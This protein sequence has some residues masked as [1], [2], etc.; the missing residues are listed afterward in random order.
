MPNTFITNLAA[1]LASD[2]LGEKI[3]LAPSHRVGRQWLDQAAIRMGG[4]ANVGIMT[5]RR[6][7]RDYAE[8]GLRKDNLRIPTA[9]EKTRLIGG[10]LERIAS[11]SGE[12]A[13][14][15]RLPATLGL[16]ESLAAAVDELESASV[17][18]AA[19]L[20][21]SASTREKGAEL[22]KLYRYWKGAG[23]RDGWAGLE[24]VHLAAMAALDEPRAY[25]LLLLPASLGEDFTAM[26]WGFIAKWPEERR[27]RLA[28]DGGDMQ[29]DVSFFTADCAINEARET[30]RRTMEQTIPLDQ[31]EIVCIDPESYIPA[32]CRAGLEAFGG[33]PE[34]L[35]ITF[36]AGL[37]G[38]YTRPVRLLTAWLEWIESGLPP[39][40]LARMI[41][42]GLLAEGWREAAPNISPTF[43]ASRLR[44]L[45]INGDPDDYRRLPGTR[46]NESEANRAEAWLAARVLDIL[47]L[48]NGGQAL[49]LDDAPAVLA[50]AEKLLA[51]ASRHDAKLDAYARNSAIEAIRAWLPHCAWPAFDAPAWLAQLAAGTRVMGLG[52][53]PGRIHVSDVHSGGHSGRPLT[54]IVGLDD[55]RFPGQLRQDPVLLDRERA[56]VSPHLPQSGQRRARREN[57]LKRL[58]ARLRGRVVVSHARHG[59]AGGREL[60]PAAAFGALAERYP[61]AMS[62]APAALAPD[63]ERKC[64]DKRDDWLHILLEQRPGGVDCGAL[65]QWFPHFAQGEIALAAR[66]SAE[67]TPYDGN[68]PEA[69]GEWDP[70]AGKVFSPTDLELLASCPQEFFFKKVLGIRPPDR[71]DPRPGSWL[72]G[73]QRGTLLHDLFQNFLDALDERSEPVVPERWDEQRAVLAEMLSRDIARHR[74]QFPPRDILAYRREVRE[75]GEACAIFLN[76][77]AERQR[78]GR[79]LYREVALG[80]ARDVRTP[81]DREQPV[82]VRL[83]SGTD[84]LLR[85]RVDR[86]DRLND[87]GG[88]VI[89]DY[90]TGRS[91][92]F[93][94]SDPFRQG[95]HLQ[96]LLYAHMVE[97]ALDDL[98]MPEPVRAFAYFFPMPRDEGLT[99]TFPRELLDRAGMR[100]VARLESLLSEGHFPFTLDPEDVKY[101]DYLPLYGDAAELA[102][103]HRAK[104]RSDPALAGWGELRGIS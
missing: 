63:A 60:Y 75:L 35:P 76:R 65:A 86:I 22:A 90:K 58:L 9:Q 103:S 82:A 20:A 8:P 23:I 36:N 13:Y 39:E 19:G 45:P 49:A 24:A 95:R 61:G 5:I 73:N 89:F 85:G 57:A 47:P 88:L 32:L 59:A 50:A 15:T 55:S 2:P 81:W 40:G 54:F 21:A 94:R 72:E 27:L 87:H 64:L 34:E 70:R 42:S 80:G 102:G 4:I 100:I 12:A 29:A 56:G 25:P 78:L 99:L 69:G 52:P 14:F 83:A 91:D 77:E 97:A 62:E 104:T 92:K 53:M 6:L 48:A 16:V 43:L 7:V 26:E 101:S 11:E 67:F 38:A 98:H 33:R 51:P 41:D 30:L 28:E 96:P 71:Y 66:E 79:P 3:L 68:V 10:I 44:A 46:D 31:V 17:R 37:P 84:L 18:S 93:S 74:R 1:A